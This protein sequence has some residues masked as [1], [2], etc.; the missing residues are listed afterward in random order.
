MIRA[1]TGQY[2]IFDDDQKKRKTA[3]IVIEILNKKMDSIHVILCNETRLLVSIYVD[4]ITEI[5]GY[6]RYITKNSSSSSFGVGGLTKLRT[7]SK[8]GMLEGIASAA[9]FD[10]EI[11]AKNFGKALLEAEN[12]YVCLLE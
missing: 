11:L 5:T 7:D 12:N 3:L 4:S 8:E 1:F 2:L 9:H 10:Y 6:H